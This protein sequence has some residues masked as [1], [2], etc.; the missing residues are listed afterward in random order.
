MK[1]TLTGRP[2]PLYRVASL[3]KLIHKIFPGSEIAELRVEFI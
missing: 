3:V 1:T 2:T